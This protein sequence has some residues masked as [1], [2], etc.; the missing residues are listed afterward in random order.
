MAILGFETCTVPSLVCRSSDAPRCRWQDA[1]DHS[2]DL[3]LI[4]AVIPDVRT[5]DVRLPA[6][7]GKHVLPHRPRTAHVLEMAIFKLPVHDD[8]GFNLDVARLGGS[9]LSPPVRSVDRSRAVMPSVKSKRVAHP[10][11]P[12]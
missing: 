2:D 5:S 9:R 7:I 11:S 6:M 10:Y 1:T 8:V 4:T 3:F 12:K